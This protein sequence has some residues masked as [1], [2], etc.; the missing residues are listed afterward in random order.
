MSDEQEMDQVTCPE[1]GAMFNTYN[2]DGVECPC[3][4]LIFE[5][6]EEDEAHP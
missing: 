5:P 4:G 1:C 2:V 3:C 6:S